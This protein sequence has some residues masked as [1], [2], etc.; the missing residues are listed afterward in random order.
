MLKKIWNILEKIIIVAIIFISAIVVIQR[1]SN[2]EKTFLG[3]RLFR[4][5][6]GSMIPKYNIGDVILVKETEIDKIEVGDDVTYNGKAGSMKGKIVTH[7]V[8]E[9]TEEN[10]KK[11]FQT[12]GV[13][14]LAKDPVIAADQILGVVQCK[15]YVITLICNALSNGYIF[16]FCAVIPLT[17][18]IFFTV[19]K[20]NV[21]KY[22]KMSKDKED[23][24]EGE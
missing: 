13:A 7:Q 22:E 2:N 21:N 23:D 1:V 14:N 16:Y 11:I 10:G 20:R 9:I 18:I 6:T 3:F 8:I 4:V 19:L 5:E 12:K 24:E 17:V 15:L